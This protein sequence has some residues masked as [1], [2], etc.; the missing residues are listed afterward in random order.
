MSTVS[1]TDSMSGT[2]SVRNSPIIS[3]SPVVTSSPTT[4]SMSSYFCC[5]YFWAIIAP[6]TSS[7][8]VMHRTSMPLSRALSTC[9]SGCAT[10]SGNLITPSF[11]NPE[12]S[13]WTWVSAFPIGMTHPFVY[14]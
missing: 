12:N 9:V 5:A 8:S 14:F 7:W 3:P 13:V 4:T 1:S 11:W 2:L 6:W 10:D